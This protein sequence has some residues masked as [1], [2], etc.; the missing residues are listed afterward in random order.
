M[1]MFTYLLI[2]LLAIGP[3]TS[4]AG[5]LFAKCKVS[6][7]TDAKCGES[8]CCAS[9][10]IVK[11][12]TTDEAGQSVAV[13]DYL[14]VSDKACKADQSMALVYGALTIVCG[15]S[16][17]ASKSVYGTAAGIALARVCNFGGIAAG[18]SDAVLGMT[19]GKEA[20]A[21]AASSTEIQARNYGMMGY[22]SGAFGLAR[23]LAAAGMLSGVSAGAQSALQSTAVQGSKQAGT[24][25][26]SGADASKNTANKTGSCISFAV[27]AVMTAAKQ[28]NKSKIGQNSEENFQNLLALITS[29]A[30]APPPLN[31]T[32]GMNG[33][34]AMGAESNAPPINDMRTNAHEVAADPN[35]KS[36]ALQESFATAGNSDFMD[37]KSPQAYKEAMD[38]LNEHFGLT[39][40]RLADILDTQ[41][42]SGAVQTAVGGEEG[43]IVGDLLRDMEKE[44]AGAP[45]SLAFESSIKSGGSPSGKGSDPFAN[46]FGNRGPAAETGGLKTMKFS[47]FDNDIWHTGTNLSIFEIVSKKTTVVAPRVTQ[48]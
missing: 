29:G 42:I 19:I 2:A 25:G 17:V 5:G 23:G 15:I 16:C 34:M 10:G 11:S 47:G 18:L 37:N 21:L 32:S 7:K 8:A 45:T 26:K 44:I 22:A 31:P 36:N 13:C 9:N 38:A 43:Q 40:D 30:A 3:V 28:Y 39:P 48:Q 33:N 12:N 6:T 46:L 20:K 24:A 4:Q 14:K 35:E 27:N 41:G 1:R